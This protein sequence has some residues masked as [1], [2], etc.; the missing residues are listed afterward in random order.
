MKTALLLSGDPRFCA[1]FDNQLK[2]LA[3]SEIHWYVAF[4]GKEYP[5]PEEWYM[6]RFVS[7]LWRNCP[8]LEEAAELIKCRL[9]KGHTLSAVELVD[10]DR[11]KFEIPRAEYLG[12]ESYPGRTLC[13][14]YMVKKSWELL[15]NS[16]NTYDLVFKSR[17]DIDFSPV[18]DLQAVYNN[19][20]K[21]NNTLISEFHKPAKPWQPVDIWAIGLQKDMEKYCKAFDH[22]TVSEPDPNYD[23]EEVMWTIWHNQGLSFE[24]NGTYSSVRILGTG[25]RGLPRSEWWPDFGVWK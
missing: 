11:F 22:I 3:N 1:D 4:W 14:W 5:N 6:D 8:S 9:P 19:L 7:P 23:P 15:A 20:I 13:Q 18:I 17:P 2:K 25:I 16:G 21:K 24:R 12:I 10:F